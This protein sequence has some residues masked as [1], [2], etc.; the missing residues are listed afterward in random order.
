MIKLNSKI[1]QLLLNNK[2]IGNLS[3]ITIS[4]IM[5]INMVQSTMQEVWKDYDMFEVPNSNF[6]VIENRRFAIQQF[7]ETKRCLIET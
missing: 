3:E 7:Y 6:S 4:W 2:Q 1:S 5:R